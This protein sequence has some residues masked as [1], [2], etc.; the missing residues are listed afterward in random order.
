MGVILWM[1]HMLILVLKVSK[2]ILNVICFIFVPKIIVFFAFSMARERNLLITIFTTCSV[3][4]STF[5]CLCQVSST[6]V[7]ELHLTQFRN[8]NGLNADGN[9]CNGIRTGGKCSSTCRTFFRI[10]LSHYQAK[11]SEDPI[12]T[13]ASLTSPVLGENDLEFQDIPSIDF[14]N[15]IQF[16]ITFSWPVCTT[17]SIIYLLIEFTLICLFLTVVTTLTI[18]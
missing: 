11:I 1:L 14:E 13:F 18:T 16:P 7:F 10:C 17:Y 5:S 9:C 15:P 2:F 6:G 12:C 8:A 3:G 4:F